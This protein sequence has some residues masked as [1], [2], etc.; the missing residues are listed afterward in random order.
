MKNWLKECWIA[1]CVVC[2]VA[3]GADAVLS[4]LTVLNCSS[5][6][7]TVQHLSFD[8]SYLQHCDPL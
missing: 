3:V 6:R 5:A 2:S 8:K 1:A 4:K 7:G